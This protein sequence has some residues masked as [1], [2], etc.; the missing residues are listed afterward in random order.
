MVFSSPWESFS[1]RCSL[2]RPNT[3]ANEP[4]HPLKGAGSSLS[5]SAIG[6]ARLWVGMAPKKKE[7]TPVQSKQFSCSELKEGHRELIKVKREAVTPEELQKQIQDPSIDI[8][9]LLNQYG[10]NTIS[11]SYLHLCLM[12][13]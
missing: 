3:T 6:F 9:V 12:K 10:M 7:K 5:H 13:I 2:I 1:G 8:Q 4:C 11:D